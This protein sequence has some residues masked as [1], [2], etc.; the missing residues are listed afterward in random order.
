MDHEFFN[1]SLLSIDRIFQEYEWLRMIT[2]NDYPVL[3]GVWNLLLLLVP[4]L[5]A[6]LLRR[7]YNSSK[8]RYGRQKLAAFLLFFV[9]LLFIPNT[10]YLLTD[11]R[12]LMGYCPSDSYWNV[13]VDSA[14]MPLAFFTYSLIGWLAFVLLLNQ[15]RELVAVVYTRQTARLFLVVV[16]P[17]IALGVLLGLIHRFNSWDIFVQPMTIME[18][19]RDYFLSRVYARNWLIF[20]LF[21]YILYFIGDKVIKPLNLK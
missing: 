13:C 12:H 14:W 2:L 17:L 18:T 20:T 1:N 8:F 5:V 21:L 6:L 7:Y 15:M 19:I 3:M 16:I 9:W 11:I 10:A 4:F